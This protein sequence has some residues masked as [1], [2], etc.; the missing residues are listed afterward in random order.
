MHE[1]TTDDRAPA[2]FPARILVENDDWTRNPGPLQAIAIRN[3]RNGPPES[4]F[5]SVGEPVKRHK[6]MS[7]AGS[8]KAQQLTASALRAQ[9]GGR[10]RR[11]PWT[12]SCERRI[13]KKD[14]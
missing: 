8:Q 4:L 11:A 1:R 2:L 12:T 14:G 3:V 13:T 5:D 7:V 6:H 10:P 9:G